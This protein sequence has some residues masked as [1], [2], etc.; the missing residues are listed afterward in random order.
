MLLRNWKAGGTEP[1]LQ[2]KRLLELLQGYDPETQSCENI[3]D[4]LEVESVNADVYG[5]VE[6]QMSGGYRLQIVPVSSSEDP[7]DEIWRL[8][9]PFGAHFIARP[10][11][12]FEEQEGATSDSEI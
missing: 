5:G 2:E 6:I 3:T 1:S 7:D 4:L 9:Q 11:G 12:V 10:N 8:F